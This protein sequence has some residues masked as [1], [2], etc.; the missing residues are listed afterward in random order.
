MSNCVFTQTSGTLGA[1]GNTIK[2]GSHIVSYSL[3]EIGNGSMK[4]ENQSVKAGVLQGPVKC[5]VPV[6]K[7]LS[8]SGVICLKPSET[9]TISLSGEKQVIYQ[10]FK[11]SSFTGTEILSNTDNQDISFTLNE[12]GDYSV[13]AKYLGRT[14]SEFMNGFVSVSTIPAITVSDNL[15]T[16]CEG[17]NINIA[18][19][20]SQAASISYKIGDNPLQQL[21]LTNNT[22]TILNTGVLKESTTFTLVSVTS[23]QSGCSEEVNVVRALKVNAIPAL[24]ANAEEVC[25]GK[26]LNITTSSSSTE[27][28]YDWSASYGST[29]G[30]KG[31]GAGVNLNS[32]IQETLFNT[33]EEVQNIL[34]TFKPRIVSN[35]VQCRGTDYTLEV[36]VLPTPKILKTEDQEVCSGVNI[37]I[38]LTSNVGG[39]VISWRNQLTGISGRNIINEKLFNETGNTITNIYEVKLNATGC[40]T[41]EVFQVKVLVKPK[42]AIKIL[43]S[44]V[45]CSPF[46]N[47][48]NSIDKSNSTSGLNYTFWK[49]TSL[50]DPV[51]NPESVPEGLY[52]VKGQDNVGCFNS[53]RILLRSPLNFIVSQPKPLCPDQKGDLTLTEITVGSQP[54]LTYAYFEDESLQKLVPNPTSVISGKYFIQAKDQNGCTSVK[55]IT[56]KEIISEN[57]TLGTDNLTVCSGS[58]FNFD[59]KVKSDFT[60]SWVRDRFESVGLNFPSSGKGVIS[61]N[62]GTTETPVSVTYFYSLGIPGCNTLNN[63]SIKVTVLPKP[64][65]KVLPEIEVCGVFG[66]LSADNII[67]QSSG[68]YNYAYLDLNKA[69]NVPVSN[70]KQVL[71]GKYAIEASFQGCTNFLPVQV[72]S[73]VNIPALPDTSICDPQRLNLNNL[74]AG[75]PGIQNYNVG[76]WRDLEQKQAV[77]NPA[78]TG[79]GNYFISFAERTGD[80]CSTLIPLKIL[81]NNVSLKVDANTL[82]ICSGS[83]LDIPL[84]ENAN[85]KYTWNLLNA[86]DGNQTSSGNGS[87]QLVLSNKGFSTD[88]ALINLIGNSIRCNESDSTILKVVVL[89][90]PAL[91][92]DLGLDL[93]LCADDTLKFNI[94]DPAAGS[95]KYYIKAE[96]NGLLGGIYENGEVVNAFK[97]SQISENLLNVENDEKQVFYSFVPINSDIETCAGDTILMD[98]Y[99]VLG[100]NDAAC[101]SQINGTIATFDLRKIQEVELKI[102][103]AGNQKLGVTNSSGAFYFTGLTNNLDYT[104]SS[105]LD[106]NPLNGVSTLDLLYL[107]NHLSGKSQLPNPYYL[108]AADANN[109]RNITV[110]D[111][112]QIKKL[113]LGQISRFPNNLSWRFIPKNFEFPNPKN[114]WQTIFPE[115]INLNNLKGSAKSDFIGVKIGDL[116]GNAIANNKENTTQRQNLILNVTTAQQR[117]IPGKT[118]NIPFLPKDFEDINGLQFTI[119]LDLNYLKL[120][121]NKIKEIYEDRIAVFENQGMITFSLV[122]PIEKDEII[123]ELPIQVIREGLLSERLFLNS[124]ITV[125]EGY[126]RGIAFPMEL[127]FNNGTE[128]LSQQPRLY[129]AFPNPFF[130]SSVIAFW[131]PKMEK[132]RITVF[133]ATGQKIV[134]MDEILERGEHQFKLYKMM[135]NNDGVYFYKIETNTWSARGSLVL[136]SQ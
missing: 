39:A 111:L 91:K 63:K 58:T 30:G 102:T 22:G 49:N 9:S 81:S 24:I 51:N 112:I 132:V 10:L 17:G 124:R 8:L 89:P 60:F 62:F 21:L 76:F 70:A 29:T 68:V 27:L 83:T 99:S 57:L 42:P 64:S 52:F 103:N 123:L 127:E 105:K 6:I 108:I 37:E 4:G 32:G 85:L 101:K 106:K 98:S 72:K 7:N 16:V 79:S 87:I 95:F 56:I 47:L 136:V 44:L 35:G 88:T 33:S 100:I 118:L 129:P 48:E 120:D 46:S 34:Y 25:S 18:L 38:P 82:E 26:V 107:Q 92:V 65:F 5:V 119:Q 113:I 11:N 28:I 117:L 116:T 41:N 115:V 134:E 110:G 80:N 61:D 135:L 121:V 19:S 3:G 36:K 78:Q 71:P 1:A 84:N 75:I 66:N 90:K 2:N 67:V 130:E 94:S 69:K 50:T 104:I 45:S 122:K 74:I 13:K 97:V 125:A 93:A 40:S 128:E 109:S 114:P 126:Q 23:L 96:Y 133:Q 86:K 15:P 12:V 20:N 55:N 131:I 77:L 14:C 73:K 43:T 31:S 54:D 53:S 59:P